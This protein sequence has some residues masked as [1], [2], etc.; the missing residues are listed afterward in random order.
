MNFWAQ[1]SLDVAEPACNRKWRY[2]PVADL[3]GTTAPNIAQE[4][5]A[6]EDSRQPVLA[7]ELVVSLSGGSVSLGPV[8]SRCGN[9]VCVRG[10]VLGSRAKTRVSDHPSDPISPAPFDMHAGNTPELIRREH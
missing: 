9:A 6:A 8:T 10:W 3:I 7:L 4:Q 1:F 2:V 5:L